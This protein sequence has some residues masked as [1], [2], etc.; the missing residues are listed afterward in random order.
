MQNGV[1]GR[2]TIRNNIFCFGVRY[3]IDRS[4]EVDRVQYD[5]V[6]FVRAVQEQADIVDVGFGHS[7]NV[8]LD[9]QVV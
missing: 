8:A 5:F 2:G 1:E 9:E 3:A 6:F 4:D 7:V